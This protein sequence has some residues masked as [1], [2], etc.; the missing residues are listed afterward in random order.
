MNCDEFEESTRK[1]FAERKRK[2]AFFLELASRVNAMAD[3]LSELT[4]HLRETNDK[5]GEGRGR[6]LY[7]SQEQGSLVEALDIALRRAE[8]RERE[9]QSE[10][11]RFATPGLPPPGYPRINPMIYASILGDPRFRRPPS[12]YGTVYHS[13]SNPRRIRAGYAG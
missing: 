9:R 8:L 12:L 4:R 1:R 5:L 10:L 2:E 7:S 3:K 11:R 6:S 13:P